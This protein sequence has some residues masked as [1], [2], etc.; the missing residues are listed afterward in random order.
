MSLVHAILFSG[1]GEVGTRRVAFLRSV[2]ATGYPKSWGRGRGRESRQRQKEGWWFW[3]CLGEIQPRESVPRQAGSAVCCWVQPQETSAQGALTAARPPQQGQGRGHGDIAAAAAKSLQ[4]CPTL[5]P[6][7]RQPTRTWA[8]HVQTG[9]ENTSCSLSRNK[10]IK[11][12]GKWPLF[13]HSTNMYGAPTLCQ[14]LSQ[15]PEVR[16]VASSSLHSTGRDQN[17]EGN[18]EL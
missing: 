1:L 12:W 17:H 9:Y 15:T 16:A 11:A 10:E 8:H 6:H 5:R 18:K 2:H 4:S 7:R 3:W 13:I 14:V